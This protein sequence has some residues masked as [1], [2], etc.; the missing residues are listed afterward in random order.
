M[1]E[2]ALKLKAQLFCG[3]EPA[4][5][6][7]KADLLEAIDREGSISAAGRSLGMSYRRSWLLVDSM[8]RCWIERLVE[9]TAGGGAAKGAR[10]TDC[11]RTVLASYRALERRLADAARRGGLDELTALM[12]AAPLPPSAKP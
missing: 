4:I 8:N 5:G 6:P 11:G 3:D 10:L 12:R 1:R 9:T 2:G 7:G